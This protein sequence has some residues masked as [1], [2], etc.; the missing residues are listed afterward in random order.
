LRKVI[1]GISTEE[2]PKKMTTKHIQLTNLF[3]PKVYRGYT[4][5]DMWIE[6]EPVGLDPESGKEVYLFDKSELTCDIDVTKLGYRP[7]R[8]EGS[9]KFPSDL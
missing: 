8:Y 4:R 6:A 7:F 1:F 9:V 5:M 2:R 3:V